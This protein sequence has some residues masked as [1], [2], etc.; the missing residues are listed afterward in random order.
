MATGMFT[1]N[2]L[3]TTKYK[4]VYKNTTKNCKPFTLDK[5]DAVSIETTAVKAHLSICP[6]L[7]GLVGS[8]GIVSGKMYSRHLFSYSGLHTGFL[9][10]DPGKA[11]CLY[12]CVTSVYTT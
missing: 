11:H 6:W 2:A 5:S 1:Y 7:V 4:R 3:G 8:Q 10:L 9:R 12:A